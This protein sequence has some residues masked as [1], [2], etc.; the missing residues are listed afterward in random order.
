MKQH[1]KDILAAELVKAGL[2]DM[3]EKAREGWYH[4]FLSP[5]P[6]PCIQLSNDLAAAGT[7]AAMEL[8]SRHHNGEF[9]ASADESEAWAESDE[10][11]EVFQQLVKGARR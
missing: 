11:Q 7:P 5:L 4:D 6:A 10:G 9:D 1:T 8:R 2:P 3:A